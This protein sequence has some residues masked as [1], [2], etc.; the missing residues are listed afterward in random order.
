MLKLISFR[1]SG[2]CQ[3]LL[4]DFL[5]A[6]RDLTRRFLSCGAVWRF[7]RIRSKILPEKFLRDH[8][9]V[10]LRAVCVYRCDY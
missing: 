7:R 1:G 6:E 4:E 5:A 8:V 3:E 9:L 10:R 2:A